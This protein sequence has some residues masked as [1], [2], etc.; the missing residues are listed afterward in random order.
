MTQSLQM[1]PALMRELAHQVTEILI[2]RRARLSAE[3]AWDGSSG[4]SSP[5]ACRRIRPSKADRRAT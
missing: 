5:P 2:E 3:R 4:R 1:S